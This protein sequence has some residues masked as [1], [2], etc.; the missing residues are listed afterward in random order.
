MAKIKVILDLKPP[1]NQKKIK[2]FLGHTGYYKKFIPT[3]L[4]HNFPH[5]Q[6]IE[7]RSRVPME[8]RMQ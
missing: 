5:R 2:I 3:L 1:I 7:E 8:P 4:Q 6:A